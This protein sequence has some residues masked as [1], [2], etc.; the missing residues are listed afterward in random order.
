MIEGW[1]PARG[2]SPYSESGRYFGGSDPQGGV[3]VYWYVARECW[4][5]HGTGGRDVGGGFGGIL[6]LRVS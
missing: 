5:M 2:A 3:E 6:R 4:L 1:C